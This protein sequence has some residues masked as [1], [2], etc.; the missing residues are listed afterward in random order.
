MYFR[1]L[2]S[3]VDKKENEK[4]FQK[5]LLEYS[6][7]SSDEIWKKMY[8][9]VYYACL[10][11]C[12]SIFQKRNV[13]IDNEDMIGFATDSSTYCMKFI[14]KGVKPRKLSSYCYLRCRYFIDHP[15]R[16]WYDKNVVNMEEFYEQNWTTNKKE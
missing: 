6:N 13:I 8:L 3:E 14:K 12:K 1:E 5:L 9:C 7:N 4:N 15:K 16:V 2:Y 10:N 11:I